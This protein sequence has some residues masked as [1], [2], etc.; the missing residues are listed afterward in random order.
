MPLSARAA[1]WRSLHERAL[2]PDLLCAFELG[3]PLRVELQGDVAVLLHVEKLLEQLL[4]VVV[5]LGRRLHEVAAP[6]LGL[7]LALRHRHLPVLRLVALVAHQ[8][9]GDVGQLGA[10]HLL[11]DLPYGPQLL[12]R[13]LRGA[14]VH[15]DEGVALGDGQSLHR[16]ELVRAGRVR[17][18]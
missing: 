6:R 4:D 8:H 1:R 11:D 17:N 10:L 18:L 5:G 3:L 12:E 7:G 14:R 2:L 16:G 9:D 15:Q 13:L